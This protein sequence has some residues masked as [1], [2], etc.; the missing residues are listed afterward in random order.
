[1]CWARKAPGAAR[2][3]TLEQTTVERSILAQR[4]LRAVA[5][6]RV[7]LRERRGR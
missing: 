1:W 3:L 6:A 7:F 4:A 2:R 5:R